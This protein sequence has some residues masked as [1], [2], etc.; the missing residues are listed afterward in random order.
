MANEELGLKGKGVEKEVIKELDEAM[1]DLIG[2]RQKRMKHGQLE[3]D[4]AAVV[5]QLYKKHKLKSYQFDDRFYD[6]KN[7]EKVVVHKDDS[8]DED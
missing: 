7:V 3:K 2:H 8:D 6:L 1:T 4:C 5:I